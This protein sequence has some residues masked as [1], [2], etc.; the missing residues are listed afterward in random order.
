MSSTRSLGVWKG[1]T[2]KFDRIVILGQPPFWTYRSKKKWFYGSTVHPQYLIL[3]PQ[4]VC[5]QTLIFGLTF[6]DDVF[7]PLHQPH[8]SCLGTIDVR[9]RLLTM[10]LT[11]GAVSR[12]NFGGYMYTFVTKLGC[13]M[14]R[15]HA[16]A[17]FRRGRLRAWGTV[18]KGT[19]GMYVSR[20][21]LSHVTNIWATSVSPIEC[22]LQ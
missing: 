3:S 5:F 22:N 8:T 10:Q 18:T 15:L 20:I 1:G 16:R 11:G 4:Y 9:K 14:E 12:K 7:H 2:W 17:F 13:T 21:H 19:H 6:G